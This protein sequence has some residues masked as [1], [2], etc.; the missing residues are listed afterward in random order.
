[1][2]GEKQKELWAK[3]VLWMVE[4]YSIWKH[5]ELTR[6]RYARAP[7]ALYMRDRPTWKAIA[8]GLKAAG[9]ISYSTGTIDVPVR[10][11]IETANAEMAEKWK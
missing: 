9:F 10:K 2:R 4:H 6:E 7:E 1:M 3:K 5:V 11:L 8:D